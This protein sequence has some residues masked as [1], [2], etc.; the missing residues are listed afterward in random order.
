MKTTKY[1]FASIAA[2]LALTLAARADD[3]S[4]KITDTHICCGSC[5]KAVAKI[6]ATVPGVTG[7]ADED[8]SSISLSAPDTATVQKAVDAL[9]TAGF[10]G[11]SSNPDIKIV[12]DTGATGA[13]VQTLKIENAHVCCGKCVK[14]INDALG[15]VPGVTGNTV[16]KGASTFTVTG[17]FTDKDVTDALQKIGLTGKIAKD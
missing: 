12:S 15:D 8:D 7:S 16:T 2:A 5:V 4:A 9:V 3:V 11:K 13:K 1:L 6:I 10:Y 17:N 14:A